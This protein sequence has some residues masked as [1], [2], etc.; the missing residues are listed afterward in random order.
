[1]GTRKRVFGS[2]VTLIA[3]FST[4]HAGDLV[5]NGAVVRVANTGDNQPVFSIQVS[6][7]SPNLCGGGWITFPVSAAAD[8]EAHRRA[9]AAALLALS[10]GMNVRVYNY[11]S[12]SCDS[13]AYIELVAQ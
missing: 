12:N 1:M 9:Y 11:Q 13:A 3:A 8:V 7:G 4:A 10:T 6:G 2:L 5:V